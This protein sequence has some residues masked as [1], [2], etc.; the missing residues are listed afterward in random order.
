MVQEEQGKKTK[1]F[2]K[3]RSIIIAAR[4]QTNPPTEGIGIQSSDAP[5]S[6]NNTIDSK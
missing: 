4:F 6:L 1:G 5:S 3:R 2:V